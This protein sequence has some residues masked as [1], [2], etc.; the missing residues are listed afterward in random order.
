MQHTR[1]QG[2]PD[3]EAYSEP[4][5][6]LRERN[7]KF[8]S[9]LSELVEKKVRIPIPIVDMGDANPPARRTVHQRACDGFTSARSSIT[10]PALSN[11]NTWQIPSHV[12]NTINNSTKFHGLEDEDAPRH[13]SRFTRICDTFRITGATDDA[14]LLRLFLFTLSGCSATWLNT[15]P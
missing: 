14:I 1:S 13:L 8:C 10:R 15:L 9:R 3:F 7:R 11:T 2:S 4:E 12:M 5:R 6:E